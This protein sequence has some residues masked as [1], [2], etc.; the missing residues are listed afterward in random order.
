[1]TITGYLEPYLLQFFL[2]IF[3]LVVYL[4]ADLSMFKTKIQKAGSIR[5]RT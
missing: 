4:S 1:M 3:F 2:L 5:R